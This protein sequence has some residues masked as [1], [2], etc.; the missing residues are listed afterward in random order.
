MNNKVDVNDLLD[1]FAEKR[2][3]GRYQGYVYENVDTHWRILKHDEV[4]RSLRRNL[5]E[6]ENRVVSSS[7]IKEIERRI[8]TDYRFELREQEVEHSMKLHV[9]NGV[10][11]LETGK[12]ITNSREQFLYR[13]NF[14]YRVNADIEDAPNFKRFLETSLE[15]SK[16]KIVFL[17]TMGY[18]VSETNEAHKAIFYYGESGTGKSVALNLVKKVIGEENTTAISFDDIGGQFFKASLAGSRINICPEMKGGKYRREDIF[19][20]ITSNERIMAEH[21]GEQPFE[22]VVKTKLLTAGNVFPEFSSGAGMDAILRRIVVVRFT[23]KVPVK[24]RH[25][26]EKL[27]E[28]RDVIFSLAVKALIEL[29]QR[30]YIFTEPDDSKSFL[31]AMQRDATVLEDFIENECSISSK[32]QVH[33]RKILER[34]ERFKTENGYDVKVSNREISQKI[35]SL[36]GVTRERF[37]MDGENLWGFRGIGLKNEKKNI[38]VKKTNVVQTFIPSSSKK[39]EAL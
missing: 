27:W 18:S 10:V 25:L 37:R 15:D 22:F 1:R 26:E 11:D 17:E 36:D 23:K 6:A 2:K 39:I 38:F 13:L 7:Q 30:D 24:D 19:K 9:E 29:I 20:S 34:F 4:S 21:K 33:L 3:Y 32:E 35:V 12:I 5:T 8:A 31:Q 28:E 14:S 16:K